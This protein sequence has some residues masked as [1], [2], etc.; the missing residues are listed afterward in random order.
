MNAPHVC[1]VIK[2][3]YNRLRATTVVLLPCTLGLTT[4]QRA[5]SVHSGHQPGICCATHTD[6]ANG[7]SG[8]G[9][10]Q[11]GTVARSGTHTPDPAIPNSC[12]NT[13]EPCARSGLVQ[14]LRRWRG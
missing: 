2:R 10:T 11:P 13:S 5:K 4:L 8:S 14:T 6:P 3:A 9:K 1:E 12:C 7:A